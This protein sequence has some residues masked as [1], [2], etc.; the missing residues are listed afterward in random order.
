MSAQ[1]Y[2]VSSNDTAPRLPRVRMSA[3]N[4][5]WAETL[6]I[7]VVSPTNLPEKWHA[8]APQKALH[9]VIFWH[10]SHYGKL[11]HLLPNVC[12]SILE[13]SCIKVK[14]FSVAIALCNMSAEAPCSIRRLHHDVWSGASAQ[15]V[16]TCMPLDSLE[17]PCSASCLRA[18]CGIS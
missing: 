2:F 13:G 16:R 11:Q 1:V 17:Q 4:S 3:E 9:A 18:I 7:E 10:S 14:P 12:Q 5:S 6:D 8:K 15:A